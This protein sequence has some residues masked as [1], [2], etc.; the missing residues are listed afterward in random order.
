MGEGEGAGD[1]RVRE[2]RMVGFVQTVIIKPDLP[3][4]SLSVPPFLPRRPPLH[5]FCKSVSISVAPLS[6]HS[7]LPFPHISPLS[8]FLA[9]YALHFL[10]LSSLHDHPQ[11]LAYMHR[12]C[13]HICLITCRGS[14]YRHSCC[15]FCPLRRNRLCFH[16]KSIDRRLVSASAAAP[17]ALRPL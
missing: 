10:S 16:L 15:M 13:Q 2:Q 9:L 7:A 17:S 3:A 1:S 6:P 14:I 12:L 4:L 8:C 5:S 11:A